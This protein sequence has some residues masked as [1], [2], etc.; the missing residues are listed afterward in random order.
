[1]HGRNKKH[2][3]IGQNLLLAGVTFSL[4]GALH[5]QQCPCILHIPNVWDSSRV[6]TLCI[7]YLKSG[8][9]GNQ[10]SGL[11]AWKSDVLS[12]DH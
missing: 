6:K 4:T 9:T 7:R 1:M 3:F 11:A 2:I 12:T 8:L 10:T 5:Q